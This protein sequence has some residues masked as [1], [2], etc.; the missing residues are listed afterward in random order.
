[1]LMTFVVDKMQSHNGEKNYAINL[2]KGIRKKIVQLKLLD[3]CTSNTISIASQ[4][5]FCCT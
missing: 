4:L 2:E 3:L 1:M 5:H